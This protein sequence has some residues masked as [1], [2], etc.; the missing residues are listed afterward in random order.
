MPMV[1]VSLLFL[2]NPPYDTFLF[3]VGK[4]VF[5][6]SE[7]NKFNIR[8]RYKSSEK[9]SFSKLSEGTKLL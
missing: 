4:F 7:K 2:T 6:I 5:N 1:I 9:L 3:E 8:K